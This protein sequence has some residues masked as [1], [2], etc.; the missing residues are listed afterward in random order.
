M[1]HIQLFSI[2]SYLLIFSIDYCVQLHRHI[3]QSNPERPKASLRYVD[4]CDFWK[5]LYEKVHQENKALQDKVRLLEERQRVCERMPSPDSE[6]QT[7]RSTRKRPVG[8]EEIEEWLDD[9]GTDVIVPLGDDYLR[10]SSYSK[11]RSC[12]SQVVTNAAFAAFRIFR[13]RHEL[14]KVTKDPSF[15]DHI[16]NI[17]KSARDILG[18]LEAALSDCLMP[19]WTLKSDGESQTVRLFQQ[20]MHQIALGFHASFEALNELVRTI[21]GRKKRFEIV[22]GLVNLFQHALDYLHTLSGLQADRDNEEKRSLRNKRVRMERSEYAV[23]KY[24]SRALVQMTQMDWKTGQLGHS[25]ILEGILCS[26]LTHTGHLLS[27]TIFNEHLAESDKPGNISLRRP[28]SATA[29]TKFEFRYVIPILHAA[30]GGNTNR[31]LIARVL[32]E[33]CSVTSSNLAGHLLSNAKKLLQNTLVKSAVGADVE[34]LKPPTPIEEEEAY[35]PSVSHRMEKYG[36][37]WFLESVWAL[38]GWDL[39]V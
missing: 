36:S 25:E 11:P 10:L 4:G 28:I 24:L 18:L 9:E 5:E 16:D 26:V 20:L 30:L 7:G 33:R 31:E 39:A 15:P 23:N 6:D 1:V 14:E 27:H 17:W 35:S 3:A 19:L 22:I 13:Y 12:D 34:V 2:P 29:A 21:T 32:G 38:V 8:F 37:E